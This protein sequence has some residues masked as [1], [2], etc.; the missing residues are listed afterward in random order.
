MMVGVVCIATNFRNIQ[1]TSPKFLYLKNGK[2]Y[3]HNIGK[4]WEWFLFHSVHSQ[5]F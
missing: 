4:A 2:G 1:K 5:A 3:H